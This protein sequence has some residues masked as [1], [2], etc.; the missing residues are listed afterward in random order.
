[1]VLVKRINVQ[2]LGVKGL[3]L[4]QSGGAFYQVTLNIY[5]VIIYTPG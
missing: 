1:M 4:S 2:I 5:F 3:D